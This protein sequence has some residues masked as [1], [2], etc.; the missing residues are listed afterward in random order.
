M[1]FPSA[2][3]LPGTT[4]AIDMERVLYPHARIVLAVG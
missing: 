4:L 1:A 2:G 3:P